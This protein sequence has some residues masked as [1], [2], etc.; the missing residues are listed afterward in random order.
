MAL[1]SVSRQKY[2]KKVDL[3]RMRDKNL[4]KRGIDPS[5]MEDQL[6]AV[7]ERG[8][9]LMAK[10]REELGGGGGGGEQAGGEGGEQQ[11]RSKEDIVVS[12]G[13]LYT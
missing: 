13:F 6:A 11:Q 2:L 7:E 4:E 9:E 5:S 3:P 10:Y 12:T 1:W 8:R